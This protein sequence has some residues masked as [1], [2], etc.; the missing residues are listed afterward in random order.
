MLKKT[1]YNS[2]D[3]AID[4][5]LKQN[6]SAQSLS[7]VT[8]I[9]LDEENDAFNLDS[10]TDTDVFTW[11]GLS[12]GQVKMELGGESIP[13]GTYIARLTTIDTTYTNGICWGEIEL[14]FITP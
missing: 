11:S 6:G 1:V 13:D 14:T 4:V 10:D 12:T 7:A 2:R 3:N 9:L 8:Q 5:I